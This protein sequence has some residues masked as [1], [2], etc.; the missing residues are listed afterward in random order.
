MDAQTESMIKE[1][2]VE[3]AISSWLITWYYENERYYLNI[4]NKFSVNSSMLQFTMESQAQTYL[5]VLKEHIGE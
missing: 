1:A 5:D 3:K 4:D 2:S